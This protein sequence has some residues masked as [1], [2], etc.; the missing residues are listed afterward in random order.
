MTLV[1]TGTL[2]GLRGSSPEPLLQAMRRLRAEASIPPI[3]LI[4]A[5]DVTIDQRDLIARSGVA[6]AVQHLGMLDRP[7]S[8]ALQRSADALVLITSQNTSEATSKLFE[9]L[10][11]GRP[12]VAL[13]ENN[14]AARIVRET[15]TGITVPPDNVDAIAAAL[16]KVAS[17][18]LGRAYAPRNLE[19]FT[20][21]GPAEAMAELV[22]VAIR[23]RGARQLSGVS[24][25]GRACPPPDVS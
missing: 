15:N 14:E 3:R 12:I 16:R 1:Y 22:E 25:P 10:A 24:Q 19:R 21:P 20:Y 7:D 23:R 6:D 17:G 11:S 2:A 8:Y 4:H 13:A 5:G 9:Y 18:E